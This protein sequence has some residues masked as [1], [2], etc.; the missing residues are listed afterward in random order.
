MPRSTELPTSMHEE[1][2]REK[3]NVCPA[4]D[5]LIAEFYHLFAS[6]ELSYLGDSVQLLDRGQDLSL[7]CDTLAYS[8]LGDGTDSR[9]NLPR[10]G[11]KYGGR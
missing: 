3:R 10:E 6:L 1:L 5:K 11:E 9:Q 8:V 7:I 4:R 2:I